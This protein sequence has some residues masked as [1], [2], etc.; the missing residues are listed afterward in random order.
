MRLRNILFLLLFSSAFQAQLLWEVKAPKSKNVSYIFGTH[1][2][3]SAEFLNEIP[4]VFSSF[5][6]SDVIVGEIVLNNIDFASRIQTVAKM[7]KDTTYNDLLS[8]EEYELVNSELLKT[9]KLGLKELGMLQPQFILTLYSA[10]I[11]K[12]I[13]NEQNEHYLDSYF[14]HVGVEK[15]KEIIGLETVDQQIDLLFKSFTIKRQAELL[16]ETIKHND[17]AVAQ[18]E[19][20]NALYKAGKLDELYK[21]SSEKNHS[22]DFSAFEMERLLDARNTAWAETLD[23]LMREKKCF[24]A[25]G[26]LHLPGE[27]GLLKLLRSKGF[28]IKALN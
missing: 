21:M 25:V 17:K 4:K 7:P 2:L 19:E 27:N 11:H 26:A 14:Q 13:D 5:N 22:F 20:L 23:A 15:N 28:R 6:K 18:I 9:L 3:V 10:S 16:V 8:A 1:H 24:V 12:S